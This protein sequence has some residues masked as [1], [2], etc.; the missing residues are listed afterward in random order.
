[1][2]QTTIATH[3][4]IELRPF[5]SSYAEDMVGWVRSADELRWLAPSTNSPLTAEKIRNWLKPD[6][7]AFVACARH[8]PGPIA[9]GELNPMRREPSHLWIGHVIVRPD[10]REYGIGR[11]FVQKLVEHAFGPLVARRISL[12]VFPDNLGAIACYLRVGFQIKGEE[13]HR[14]GQTGPKQRLLRLELTCSV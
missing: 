13:F 11:S 14:F 3:A 2:P 6:G 5:L 12:V 10:N 9:Y 4:P 8:E 7:V 1:M